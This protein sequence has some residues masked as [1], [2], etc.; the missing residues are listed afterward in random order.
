MAHHATIEDAAHG[1]V[2]GDDGQRHATWAG[3]DGEQ[4]YSW[5]CLCGD[6]CSDFNGLDTAT[7]ASTDHLIEVGAL[8]DADAR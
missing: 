5:S 4:V 1:I 3:Y 2:T 7:T 6:G 8:L